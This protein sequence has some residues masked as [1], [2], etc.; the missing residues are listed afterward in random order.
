MFN[1]E[2]AKHRPFVLPLNP[3]TKPDI[4]PSTFTASHLPV[5]VYQEWTTK[6]RIVYPPPPN[7]LEA[8]TAISSTAVC[9][10]WL[11]NNPTC[12]SLTPNLPSTPHQVWGKTILLNQTRW[13]LSLGWCPYCNSLNKIISLIVCCI[14]SLTLP[15]RSGICPVTSLWKFKKMHLSLVSPCSFFSISCFSCCAGTMLLFLQL[16]ISEL[17]RKSWFFSLIYHFQVTN[18]NFLKTTLM[19]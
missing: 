3:L 10:F 15:S 18:P 6:V 8:E 16:S 1:C 2:G 9:D 5:F 11:Q 14:V 13:S 17:N 12:K 19:N 4:D 7:Q